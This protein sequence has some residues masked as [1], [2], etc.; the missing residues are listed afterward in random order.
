MKS[1]LEEILEKLKEEGHFEDKPLNEK[2]EYVDEIL[3]PKLL[4]VIED[5]QLN[6]NLGNAISHIVTC[7]EFEVERL[8]IANRFL[9][10]EIERRLKNE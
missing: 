1:Y 6:F 8:R 2:M 5:Y 10:R 9:E 7:P 3:G 4:A